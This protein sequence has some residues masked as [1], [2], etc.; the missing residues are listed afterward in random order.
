MFTPEFINEAQGKFLLVANHY[1][2]SD[3]ATQASIKFNKARIVFGKSQLP[4]H[5]QN[6]N[7]TYDIRGQN[8]SDATIN[9]LTQALKDHCILGF[10]R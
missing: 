10:K 3:E 7:L 2:E 1:L 4:S 6:C 9:S 8:I 5:L